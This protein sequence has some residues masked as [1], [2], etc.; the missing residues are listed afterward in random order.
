MDNHPAD[1]PLP[2]T[3]PTSTPDAETSTP[4][5]ERPSGRE[6][7][8]ALALAALY[9]IFWQVALHLPFSGIVPV[10]VTTLLSLLLT[11]LFTVRTARG[12]RSSGAL[13]ANL[14]LSGALILPSVVIPVLVARFPEWPLWRT[15]AP[16]YRAYKQ[17][18]YFAVPGLGGL[19]LIWLA[20]S[21]GVLISRL[22]REIK[23]L[24]PMAIVLACVDMSVVFGGGLVTQANSGKNPVAKTAMSALTVKLPPAHLHRGAAPMNLSVGFADYLF[25][26]L[27]FACFARFG[28]PAR[29]TF[30]WLC[31]TLAAYMTVVA[32]SQ[33][34]LPAL[35][36]IAVVVIGANLRQF[37]YER[38]E[39]FAL[40]YA[41][42]I[43]AAVMAVLFFTRR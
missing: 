38:S 8:V 43:V 13:L 10:T 17:A 29:R 7:S 28:V 1:T 14:C 23:I 15:L 22:V 16:S 11:L 18:V 19:L 42:L 41:G 37:R 21:V 6:G 35:V 32:F 26:A 20:A 9:L 30:L 27:F 4:P 5:S 12:L 40:L 31:V 3:E 39:A 2:A 36:P 25:I 34:D 33:I 24:L